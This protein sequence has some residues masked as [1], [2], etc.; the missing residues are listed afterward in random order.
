MIGGMASYTVN[1][2]AVAKARAIVDARQYVLD[3][4]WGEVQPRADAQ[5]AYLERHSWEEYGAWHLALTDG[6]NDETKGRYAFVYGD[7]R[8]L[9]RSGLI[10]CVYRA[11][12]WRHKDV[13]AAA[14]D[15]LQHLDRTTG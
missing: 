13:E 11:M 6:A 1:D 5:N 14:Y 10:A 8:R 4:D 15:L 2:A 12:E 3:S 9:H 7:F